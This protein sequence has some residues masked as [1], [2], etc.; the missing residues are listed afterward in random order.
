MP[1]LQSEHW[2]SSVQA[3]APRTL[4][5]KANHTVNAA[6]ELLAPTGIGLCTPC[7]P[8]HQ[9]PG[10]CISS[11][12]PWLR[13]EQQRDPSE[14]H[15]NPPPQHAHTG[16]HGCPHTEHGCQCGHRLSYLLRVSSGSFLFM[17]PVS[18]STVVRIHLQHNECQPG[19]AAW[20]CVPPHRDRKELTWS[21]PSLFSAAHPQPGP[22][23]R[24][25]RGRGTMLGPHPMQPWGPPTPPSPHSGSQ[26]LPIRTRG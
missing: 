16:S 2:P 15:T 24:S 10:H 25:P 20:P 19:T 7:A 4:H 17:T 3:P 8:I 5:C 21:R 9:P 23:P 1:G 13:I 12:R 22:R 14:C 18:G 11:R 26:H 6:A